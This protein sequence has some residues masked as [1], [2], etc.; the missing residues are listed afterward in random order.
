MQKKVNYLVGTFLLIL[1]G[2]NILDIL[3]WIKY[4]LK[5]NLICFFFTSSSSSG[6]WEMRLQMW[7]TSF[8]R[9]AWVLALSGCEYVRTISFQMDAF[10]QCVLTFPFLS[11]VPRLVPWAFFI[12]TKG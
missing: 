3:G 5:I 11:P 8:S 6:Q 4:I 2:N 7:L 9:T 10:N 12:P 1:C